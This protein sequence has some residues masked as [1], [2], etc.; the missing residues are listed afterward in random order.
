MKIRILKSIKMRICLRYFKANTVHRF[1]RCKL[2]GKNVIKLIKVGLL[3]K[4]NTTPFCDTCTFSFYSIIFKVLK[5]IYLFVY[6]AIHFNKNVFKYTL[7]DLKSVS[8]LV[9]IWYNGFRTSLNIIITSNLS[10]QTIFTFDT[11]WNV[12]VLIRIIWKLML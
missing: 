2:R 1:I 6:S 3:L 11:F 4:N 10:T 5:C 12:C 9:F 7:D 8:W